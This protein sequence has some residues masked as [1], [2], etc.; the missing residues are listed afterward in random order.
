MCNYHQCI[1][2]LFVCFPF[3]RQGHNLCCISGN[4]H[5][6]GDVFLALFGP[7]GMKILQ[8]IWSRILSAPTF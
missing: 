2:Q 3:L 6:A 8:P 1:P 5:H 7:E 4:K